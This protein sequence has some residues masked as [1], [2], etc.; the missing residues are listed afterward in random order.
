MGM[1]SALEHAARH[2]SVP[3]LDALLKAGAVMKGRSALSIA[4][5]YGRANIV[6][7]LLD[8]G[9]AIDEVPDNDDIDFH[10]IDAKNAL[11]EAAARGQLEVVKLLLERGAD[12][13][14]TDT[15]GKSAVE[16][17]ETEEHEDCTQVLKAAV[18]S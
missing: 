6:T 5:R 13:R 16:L 7:F 1:S 8:Q 12:P 10:D 9:A 4:A 2:S 11:C 17:A 3:T 15:N 18:G 14:V